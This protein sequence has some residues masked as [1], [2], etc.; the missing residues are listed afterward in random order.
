MKNCL[1]YFKA[2]IEG[3]GKAV[4]IGHIQSDD[5]DVRYLVLRDGRRYEGVPGTTRFR[6]VEFV[7]H[8]IPYRLPSLD[9]SDPTPRAMT[10][11][12]LM[13]AGGLEHVPRSSGA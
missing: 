13:Q 1:N 5:P 12:S 4:I 6:V 9:P 3:K 10:M 7:E 8:G 2:H 11:F